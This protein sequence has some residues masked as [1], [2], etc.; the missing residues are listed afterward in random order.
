MTAKV[1]G[2]L[3]SHSGK[4]AT[5]DELVISSSDTA[6]TKGQPARIVATPG[7][8]GKG[9][10]GDPRFKAVT[11]SLSVAG[12]THAA[13]GGD[14][15]HYLGATMQWFLHHLQGRP[16]ATKGNFYA[17][18]IVP[19]PVYHSVSRISD[20]N[21]LEPVT[22]AAVLA[23][24]ADAEKDGIS[25]MVF[26]TYRSQELQEIYYQKKVTKL[27]KVGV[28]HYGLACDIVKV[29]NGNPSWDGSFDF[30]GE[31]AKKHGLIWGGDWGE[32]GK[33]HSFVD[34]DHV[35]RC[36]ITM[37]KALFAETWYPD[38]DY[39]PYP[40]QDSTADG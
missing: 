17:D 16:T 21:Y 29:V 13:P 7:A 34:S 1:P 23:I 20:I 10:A 32:P 26:E 5:L 25:L 30:L 40:K 4:G 39:S 22:R 37:Q 11:S 14:L 3:D 33:K 9:D 12:S 15:A 18:V 8:L 36:T 38:A 6:R 27:K 19:S 35:Q 2:P 31:L 28:H 24:I